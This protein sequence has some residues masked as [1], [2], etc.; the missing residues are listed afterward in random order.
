MSALRIFRYVRPLLVVCLAALVLSGCGMFKRKDP[1]VD[2]APLTDYEAGVNAS[3]AWTVSVGNG[4]GYGFAPWEHDGS[5][6]AA[7]P[8]GAVVKVATSSGSVSWRADTGR[9]LSAGVGSDG[10]TTAVAADDGSVIALDSNGHEKWVSRA[11]SNVAVPPVVGAGVVVVRS[12]DY[13]IQAFD[14]DDGELRWSVQRPGPALAL[15]T[16]MQMMMLDGMVITGMPNGKL[17]AIDAETG[18][19]QWEG[20]V[21]M[22]QGPTD[23]E[24][25]SDVVGKPQLQG[26]Y[27]CGVTYQ[28]RMACFDIARGGDTVWSQRFSSPTGMATDAAHAYAPDARSVVVAFDL[29]DGHEVW[30]QEGLRNRR[31]AAP[32]VVEQAVAVAD[33]EGYVHFL[34]RRD[35]RLLGRLNIGGG[36]VLSPLLAT[37]HGIV[38][39]AGNGSLHRISLR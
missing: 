16:S 25:I 36:R 30:K 29:E 3:L 35:G 23:L 18:S 20:T 7:A 4:S 21:G 12:G 27:L 31:L 22:A 6:Y 19:V 34:D 33:F 10:R 9:R 8:S 26:S 37:E 39:Q 1:R 5:I 24:R 17:M 32:A 13:R 15:S 14:V 38:V 28:S 2:P 11:A